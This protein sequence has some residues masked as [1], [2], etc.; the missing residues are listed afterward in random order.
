[1]GF[2]NSASDS[3]TFCLSRYRDIVT[4]VL[5]AAEGVDCLLAEEGFLHEEGSL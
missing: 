3:T 5:F 2:T 4:L 1:M